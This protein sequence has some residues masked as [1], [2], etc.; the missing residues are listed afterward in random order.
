MCSSY[1]ISHRCS[2]GSMP[3]RHRLESFLELAPMAA[4]LFSA[5]GPQRG[6]GMVY[7]WP[8]LQSWNHALSWNEFQA[9]KIWWLLHRPFGKCSGSLWG[10][11]E[12]L[13]YIHYHPLLF[14][15]SGVYLYEK[16]WSSGLCQGF[17]MFWILLRSCRWR[18]APQF[19]ALTMEA[20]QTPLIL[21]STRIV[22]K[23]YIHHTTKNEQTGI[24]VN[25]LKSML[26]QRRISALSIPQ[27]L[28]RSSINSQI[29]DIVVRYQDIQPTSD[30]RRETSQDCDFWIL[31]VFAW[32]DWI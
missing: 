29:R 11:T 27:G 21:L 6:F 10:P 3:T 32:I 8:A 19:Y 9:A 31:L 4:V 13:L 20:S 23:N 12:N 30:Q 1:D 14:S 25:F 28:Q 15:S 17:E 2:A 24:F 5:G 26:Y 22:N 18:I 7:P 16:H